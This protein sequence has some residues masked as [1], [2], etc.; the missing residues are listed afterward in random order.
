MDKYISKI[1]NIK[2]LE[3]LCDPKKVKNKNICKCNP[4][5]DFDDRKINK[6]IEIDI[7]K[8]ILNFKNII[9]NYLENFNPKKKKN[10]K[11]DIL[12]ESLW[13]HYISEY[14]NFTPENTDLK[15]FYIK[16]EN[17]HINLI[18]N[19]H[20]NLIENNN[21]LLKIDILDNIII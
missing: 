2:G 13:H 5:L 21:L 16:L 17:Y 4:E 1:H 7:D 10:N 19:Y 18:E 15:N 14:F 20:I 8:Y 11:Y 9:K 3:L 12:I 6:N